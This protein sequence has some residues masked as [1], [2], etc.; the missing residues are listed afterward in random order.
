[1]DKRQHNPIF[2]ASVKHTTII[3]YNVLMI[4]LHKRSCIIFY[5]VLCVNFLLVA[6]G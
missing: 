1:M 4:R 6:D 3:I 2:A 5:G